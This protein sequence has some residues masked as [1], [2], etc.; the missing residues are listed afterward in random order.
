M[1]ELILWVIKCCKIKVK[2]GKSGLYA[3]EKRS[4]I[5]MAVLWNWHK[6]DAEQA[7]IKFVCMLRETSGK[8]WEQFGAKLDEIFM[9]DKK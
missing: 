2:E 3:L 1:R 5:S 6:N 9:R 7:K 8:T 4:G